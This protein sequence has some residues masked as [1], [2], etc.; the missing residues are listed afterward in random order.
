[1]NRPRGNVEGIGEVEESDFSV[2]VPLPVHEKVDESNRKRSAARLRE[3][4]NVHD[5]I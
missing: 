4:V 3:I 1:M 5:A 2:H